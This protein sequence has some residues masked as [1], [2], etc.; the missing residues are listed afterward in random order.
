VRL[1]LDT[2]VV[3]SALLWGGAPERL[4][5][6]AGEGTIELVTSAALLAELAEL[7]NRPKLAAKLAHDGQ[8]AEEIVA[9]Y[10]EVAEPIEAPDIEEVRLRDP[11]DAAVLAC[12]IAAHAE[13]IVSGDKDLQSLGSYQDIPILSPAQCLQRLGK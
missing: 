6:L 3:V 5:D 2:N 12:A 11:D 4:I 13:A 7:L 9:R 1:V 10:R 8:S